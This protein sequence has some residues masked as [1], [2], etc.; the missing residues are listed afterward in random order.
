MCPLF[1]VLSSPRRRGPIIPALESRCCTKGSYHP[2]ESLHLGVW[3]PACAGTTTKSRASS[4]VLFA[5]PGKPTPDFLTLEISRVWRAKGRSSI[6]VCE[7]LIAE[8]PAPL[9]APRRRL[10]GSRA[11]LLAAIGL[12]EGPSSL[13]PLR[14]SGPL[15][16][17]Q[18]QRLRTISQLLAG[19]PSVPGRSPGTARAHGVRYSTPAGAAPC[20]TILTPHDSALDKQ[21]EGI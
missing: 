7:H 8:M 2:A 13:A 10:Y 12:P 17:G 14:S 18:S 15:S 3:V 11:A 5:A 1:A 19:D 21:D 4:P 20:S 6:S 9:G 16:I